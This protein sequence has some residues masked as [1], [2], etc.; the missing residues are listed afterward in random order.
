MTVT[1]DGLTMRLLTIVVVVALLA[2]PAMAQTTGRP[3]TAEPTTPWGHPD[4]QG[5]YTNAAQAFTPL[6]R[7]E[8]FAGRTLANLTADD[9]EKLG[10]EY[11][12]RMARE[13][14]DPTEPVPAEPVRLRPIQGWF[15]VDPP[16][17]RVPALTAAGRAR[18]EARPNTGSETNSYADFGNYERCIMVGLLSLMLPRH[19]AGVLDVTQT[20]DH[21]VIRHDLMNARRIIRLDN[22]AR[23]GST[24]RTDLGDS[25]GWWEDTTL[26]V[27]TRSFTQRGVMNGANADSFRLTERFTREPT[28]NLRW[29]ATFEDPETWTRPWT[30]SM[31]FTRDDTQRVFEFACHEGNYGLRNIL[32]GARAYDGIVGQT[33]WYWSRALLRFER[34]SPSRRAAAVA[35]AAGGAGLVAGGWLLVFRQ[36]QRRRS[37]SS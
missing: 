3:D 16:D 10:R 28:G 1:D 22:G 29:T 2:S 32:A 9:L 34:L 4:I 8:R 19:Y 35:A 23:F 20:L 13:S 12:A 15:I 7:P 37:A 27:E 36:R 18:T 11:E 24:L 14:L 17:G 33:R 5:T 21:V 30:V 26:V 6:E 25:R 31:L